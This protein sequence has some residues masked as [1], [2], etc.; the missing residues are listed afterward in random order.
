MRAVT[1]LALFV[2][3]LSVYSQSGRRASEIKTPVPL[4]EQPAEAAK[5]KPDEDDP[6]PMT[7]GKN[8]SYRCSEDGSLARIL[9]D[10][11]IGEVVVSPKQVDMRAVITAKPKPSYTREARRKGIQGFVT[12]R[13]L[14]SARAKIGRLQVLK[15]LP[16]GLTE[17]ALRA[18]CK[19][20]FKPARK[21]GEAVGQWVTAEY[22]FRL[23]DSSIF[24]P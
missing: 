19:M 24:T 3:S 1:I 22:V 11:D 9:E 21:S 20:E 14:L 16:F 2:F 5:P 15:G 10:D 8:Q 4:P 7:A 12:I 17:N 13:V 6:P 18:A 23:A